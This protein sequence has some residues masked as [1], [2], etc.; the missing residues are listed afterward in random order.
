MGV[1]YPPP[2]FFMNWL[3]IRNK[4]I[5]WIEETKDYIV[6]FD[7]D[8]YIN[9][10]SYEISINPGNSYEIQTYRLLHE[11]GHILIWKNGTYFDAEKKSRVDSSS[12]KVYTLLEEAEAWKRG[13]SLG[14]KIGIPIDEVKWEVEMTTALWNYLQWAAKE[15]Y[16]KN[17][18]S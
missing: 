16:G 9:D 6:I 11:C 3:L 18:D 10:I 5:L 2:F 4:L 13:F 15:G 1:V 14:R 12:G 17:K 8:D 7:N